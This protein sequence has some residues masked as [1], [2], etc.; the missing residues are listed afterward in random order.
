[1]RKGHSFIY[2]GEGKGKTTQAIGQGIRAV[3]N[4]L[5][6][7][8]IQFLDYNNNKDFVTL[9]NLEP[10]FKIFRFEK[11]RINIEFIDE[12]ERKEIRSEILNGFNFSKKIL[13]TGE[14]DMLILDGILDAITEGFVDE[15]ELYELM[16]K[17]SKN[18]DIIITGEK[19]YNSIAEISDAVYM[20]NTVKKLELE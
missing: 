19:L 10:E 1:M 17:R 5:T 18:M 16:M 3:G 6:E 11:D 9:K 4:D 20:I 2:C 8:M 7:I 13:E 12:N 14:C 15:S